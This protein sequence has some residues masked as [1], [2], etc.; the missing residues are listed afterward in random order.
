MDKQILILTGLQPGDSGYERMRNR[1]NGFLPQTSISVLPN[2]K[3]YD[4]RRKPLK[5]LLDSGAL[6]P[7]R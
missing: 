6:G 1:F 5:R 7:P 3:S 4:V 2:E